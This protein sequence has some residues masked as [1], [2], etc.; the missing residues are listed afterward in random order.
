M[1]RNSIVLNAIIARQPPFCS[2]DAAPERPVQAAVTKTLWVL[3]Q[4]HD[5]VAPLLGGP[6]VSP[7]PEQR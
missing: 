7:P 1:L 2:V 4:G 6:R 3:I 5:W